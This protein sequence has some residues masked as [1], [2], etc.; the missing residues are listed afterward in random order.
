MVY[1]R[2][3]SIERVFEPGAQFQGVRDGEQ[4]RRGLPEFVAMVTSS[5]APA[6]APDYSMAVNLID[7][8]GPIALVKVTDRFRGRTYVDY[9]TVVKTAAGWRIVNKA[10]TTVA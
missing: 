4:V 7:I 3:A 8:T 9:L 5:D 10:F 1:G 6:P 2:A